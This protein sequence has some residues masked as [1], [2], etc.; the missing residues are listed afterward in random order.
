MKC[1]CFTCKNRIEFEEL[2]NGYAKGSNGKM[3][4]RFKQTGPNYSYLMPAGHDGKTSGG[5]ELDYYE[6]DMLNPDKAIR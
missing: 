3:Y 2:P 5:Y 1:N 4:R 6:I